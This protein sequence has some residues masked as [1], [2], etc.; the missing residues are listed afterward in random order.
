MRKLVYVSH[1]S[2]DGCFDHTKLLPNEEILDFAQLIR[3]AGLLVYG[4]IT[5]Q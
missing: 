5:Y 4:R 3:D 2:I 1:L